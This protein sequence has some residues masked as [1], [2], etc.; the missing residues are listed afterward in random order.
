MPIYSYQ[1]IDNQGKKRTGLIEAHSETEARAKLRDLQVM[2]TNV[3][4]KTAAKT[5]E[6][7]RGE[8]LLTFTIQLSHLINSG[9]PIYE[10]LI[11]LE[12]QYRTESFARIILSLCEQIKSGTPLSEAMAMYP[13]SFDHLYC[14][15]IAA[16]E[17]AGALDMVLVKLSELLDKQYK[18][19]SSIVTAMIYPAILS[20]FAL[21]V[22]SVLLGFVIP[23][24]EGIFAERQLNTFTTIVLYIS[25]IFRDY[26]WLYIP[27]IAIIASW[28]VYQLRTPTGKLWLEKTLLKTPL[29]RTLLVQAAVARFCR[30]MGT[31]LNGGLT[32][33]DSLRIAREVMNNKT[34]EEEIKRAETRIVEGSS[35][36]TELQRS[37]LIPHM[38]SRM[39]AV[40]EESGT[41][42][43]MFNKI[44]EMYEDNLENT[45]NRILAF[46]QPVILIFMGVVIG[47][48]LLAILLPMTDIS[49]FAIQT[50]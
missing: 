23:S 6:H 36:S 47:T 20:G 27:G 1:A 34:L 40:G 45:L 28:S 25:H 35:L 50:R 29:F 26:W 22:I 37:R 7:L 33:I 8:K 3:A 44:A 41:S 21:L 5:K 15:M 24:I 43:I 11:A 10:S 12:E 14:S 13:D 48:V 9:V 19:R 49:S 42:V 31:L 46:A 38:V 39:L 2:V 30:T 4:V 17:S 16:G 18:L 32:V